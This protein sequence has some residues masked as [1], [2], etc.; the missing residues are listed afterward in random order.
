MF[1]NW[2]SESKK[3][4]KNKFKCTYCPPPTEY[5]ILVANRKGLNCE[6]DI[7]FVFFL[8]IPRELAMSIVST[9]YFGFPPCK[10][11]FYSISDLLERF[12]SRV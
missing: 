4:K 10:L 3:M 12:Y 8:K 2:E 6:F 7:I 1:L 9:L 11:F 5:V